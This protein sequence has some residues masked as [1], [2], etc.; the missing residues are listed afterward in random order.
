MRSPEA[1]GSRAADAQQ[2]DHSE[3]AFV[4]ADLPRGGTR[5][6]LVQRRWCEKTRVRGLCGG[7]CPTGA[8]ASC[9]AR[10]MP[11]LALY[12]AWW[13]GE[14]PYPTR[15]T[16]IERLEYFLVWVIIAIR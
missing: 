3:E 7:T 2:I 4:G 9:R 8:P 15:L 5:R 1:A 12:A 6:P 10:S 13:S 11:T 16:M 14:R